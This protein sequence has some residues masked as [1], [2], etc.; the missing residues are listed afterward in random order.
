VARLRD[1]AERFLTLCRDAGL[2]TGASAGTP[3]V[4]VIIGDSLR[5]ARLSAM[6]FERGINV[7]PMVAPSV[8]EHLARLRFFIAATHSD[9]QLRSAVRALVAAMAE[10]DDAV[11]GHGHERRT[12]P[13]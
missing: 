11:A 4:P 2:D 9:A 8:P 5:A 6:L 3:I 13:A 7:Q 10:V 1:R 12:V